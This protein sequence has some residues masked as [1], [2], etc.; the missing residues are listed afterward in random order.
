LNKLEDDANRSVRDKVFVGG[1]DYSLTEALFHRH[2]SQFGEIVECQII[3]DP[4]TK[5]SRGFGFVRYKDPEVARYLITQIQVTKLNN[6]KID[7]RT[8]DMRN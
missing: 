2:F 3:R 6:R 1:L 7:L 5:S 8:A 4:L